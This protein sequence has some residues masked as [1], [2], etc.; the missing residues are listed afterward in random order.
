MKSITVQ[1]RVVQQILLAQLA[2]TK[3]LWPVEKIEND[4]IVTPVGVYD[5]ILMGE[6]T[7][8]RRN[9]FSWSF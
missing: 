8:F 5:E 1:M 6:K 4:C 3:I 9:L 7:I 2:N